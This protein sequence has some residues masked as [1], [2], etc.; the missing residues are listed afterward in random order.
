MALKKDLSISI[1]VNGKTH[2]LIVNASTRLLDILRERLGLTGTKHGCE[3]GTCGACTVIMDKKAVRSCRITAAEANGKEILTVEGLSQDGVLS[4]LQKSFLAHGAVQCG[5]CTPGMLMAA[6]ALLMNH[7][8][9]TR[10]MIRKALRN[11]LCRC[12]GYEPIEEAIL[13]AASETEDSECLTH[14]GVGTAPVRIDGKAKVTGAAKFAA[15][16]CFPEM[17]YGIPV[18]S[19]I[20]CGELHSIDSSRLDAVPGFLKLLTFK[21]IP[22]RNR[23]GRWRADRPVFVEKGIRY[24]GDVLALVLAE[25]ESA[26]RQAREALNIECVE[27]P[28]IFDA[29]SDISPEISAEETAAVISIEKKSQKAAPNEFFVEDTFTTPFIEH[30]LIERSAAVAYYEQDVLTL[31]GPSQ[32]VFFDRLEIMR[33]LGFSP[34]DRGKIRLIQAMTGGAFGKHEDLSAQPLAALACYHLKRPVKIIFSRP[35]SMICTTK[36][37]PMRIRHISYFNTENKLLHQDIDISADTGAYASWAPN[38]LRKAAVHSTGPYHIP[39]VHIRGISRYS[40][41]AFSGAMRGFGAV[42]TILAAE[43]HIDH[44][45]REINQDPIALRKKWALTPGTCTATGQR[46]CSGQNLIP[47]LEAAESHFNWPGPARGRAV[48]ESSAIGYGAGASFYGIGYGNAIQDKG[49]VTIQ[50]RENGAVELATSAVDYGQGS[51]TVLLQIAS[52]TLGVPWSKLSI[53]TGDTSE[54]PDSGS[55]VASR[56]TFVTGNAVFHACQKLVRHLLPIAADIA[57]E[58]PAAINVDSSGWHTETGRHI[59]WA[60]LVKRAGAAGLEMKIRHRYL[61]QTQALDSNTGQGDVYRTYAFSA[62]CAE[63][64]VDLRSGKI[65]IIRIVSAHDS[66]RIIHP[67]MAKGQVTGG[68]VMAA[69]MILKEEFRTRHG[70]P[71]TCDFDTYKLPRFGDVPKMDVIFVETRDFEG[72]YG[73]KG[74]GEPATLAA[75]PAIVN[76]VCDAL[77]IRFHSIPLTPDRILRALEIRDG[78]RD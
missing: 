42:Q 54:T 38:I 5:F 51:S 16:Y 29:F 19:P 43:C 52:E 67:V 32:N 27:T 9:V 73:A 36:R 41:S 44:I 74:L 12:T 24:A 60:L 26:A 48:S 15:D 46:M 35:E 30:G 72:P 55:T 58:H 53:R 37:R 11:N 21:D 66:G 23:L 59:P 4:R 64:Q 18:L 45:A 78:S 69:G 8:S 57:S 28:G 40:N 68:I 65:R 34:R 20:A 75:A 39:S 63:V 25:T 62:A 3:S 49:Q 33:I 2:R 50:I 77:D 61:N 1:T 76:A 56:Q 13:S 22:G 10:Q 47:V 17:C 31:I 71:V 70:H 7:S 14:P 6:T